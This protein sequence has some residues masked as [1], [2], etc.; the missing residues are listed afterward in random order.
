M[1]NP[2][3]KCESL[4]G[5][6]ALFEQYINKEIRP[7]YA[8]ILR[9]K[10]YPE[11]YWERGSDFL[12]VEVA[13]IDA[14]DGTWYLLVLHIIKKPHGRTILGME[15]IGIETD[16][17]IFLESAKKATDFFEE[18]DIDDAMKEAERVLGLITKK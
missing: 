8:D 7:D 2:A 16:G 5:Q 1:D 6:Q 13:A 9:K 17:L 18:K 3:C 15:M 12:N 4:G 14:E 11:T 10:L